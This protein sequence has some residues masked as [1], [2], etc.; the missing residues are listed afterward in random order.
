MCPC[1]RSRQT[2]APTLR[3]G[4]GTT[5]GKA[6]NPEK[7][8]R[9]KSGAGSLERRPEGGGWLSSFRKSVS[10]FHV[11]WR[12]AKPSPEIDLLR[13]STPSQEALDPRLVE[14]VRAVQR[15][16]EGHFRFS[17]LRFWKGGLSLS[18]HRH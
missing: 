11:H 15:R 10:V 8:P 17:L 2:H 1:A 6:E 7:Q 5:L 9:V 14:C 13:V 16:F 3:L 18:D 4:L 12:A